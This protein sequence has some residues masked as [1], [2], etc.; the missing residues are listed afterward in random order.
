[1]TGNGSAVAVRPQASGAVVA[2]DDWNQQR[3]DFILRNYCGGAPEPVA[4]AFI[5]ICRKR[6]LAPEE[7]QVYL[8]E[9]GGKWGIETS[10]DG[11]RLIADRTGAYAG[12]DDPVYGE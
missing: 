2:L 11:Y 7:K 1:M 3:I 9:R 6:R 12:S 8:I 4:D 5:H 10:I